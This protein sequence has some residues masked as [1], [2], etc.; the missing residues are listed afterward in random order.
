MSEEKVEKTWE[1]HKQEIEQE[2]E[3]NGGLDE[4]YK[5]MTPKDH[6]AEMTDKRSFDEKMNDH[7]TIKDHIAELEQMQAE[8]KKRIEEREQELFQKEVAFS[9]SQHNLEA[10]KDIINVSTPD[11]LEDAVQKL[12]GIVNEIK[13]GASYVPKENLKQ[14]EYETAKENK[15]VKSMIGSKLANLFK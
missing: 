4:V 5:H 7:M 2:V 15:D 6:I 11:E 10:F 8:S 3:A 13:I 9:L 1:E 12:C 14:A